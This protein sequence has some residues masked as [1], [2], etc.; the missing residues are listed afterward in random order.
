M[1]KNDPYFMPLADD[2]PF[3]IPDTIEGE[4]TETKNA[5]NYQ[6]ISTGQTQTF[7]SKKLLIGL[8]GLIM[9]MLI[10][11]IY[12]TFIAI[13]NQ[14]AILATLFA[15]VALLLFGLVV[16][17]AYLF[18]KGQVQYSKVERL[19]ELAESYVK[20]RS[21]GKSILFINEINLLYKGKPQQAYLQQALAEL[22][23]YLNDAEVIT[24]LSADFLS[25]L[26][27]EAQR[28]VTRESIVTGSMI[29]VSQLAVMD[30]L[31]VIWKTVGMVNNINTI[32]GL[33]L[34]KIGQ[35]KL[36]IS[37]VKATLLAAGTQ[38]GLNAL[39]DKTATGMAGSITGSI[40]QGMGIGTFVAKIGIEAM[41]QSRPIIFEAN[42]EPKINLITD[43]I[44]MAIGKM[45]G[46]ETNV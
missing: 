41:K 16:K 46:Q 27:K 25:H 38:V 14:S 30:S 45:K 20:E 21:H 39:V 17:E 33:S 23:D 15:L 1:E 31:I 19:R 6:F 40:T 29:A 2:T 3:A 7:M 43:S 26:D 13:L 10:W 37:I 36:L 35:W 24:R 34:T 22:P 11:Q 44:M 32:Y 12:S 42:E 28:L 18:R 8:A 9:F 5:D 4:L